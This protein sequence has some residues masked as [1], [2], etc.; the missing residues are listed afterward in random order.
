MAIDPTNLEII[1]YPHPTLRHKSKPIVKVDANLRDAIQAM[2][3]LM[4]EARGIGLAANQ[5][6]LPLRVFVLNLA[7]DPDEGEELVF[8]NPQINKPKGLD[9]KEEGCLSMPGVNGFVKRPDTIH[10]QAY[11]LSGNLFDATVDGLMARAIQHETDHLDGVLFTDKLSETGKLDIRDEL[12][13]LEVAFQST[14]NTGGVPDDATIAKR[15]K[16]IEQQYA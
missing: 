3:P 15:L 2:F 6:D 5:V 12:Y 11:D 14:Q 4:Y 8:I 7:A 1:H 9:E 10:V 16:T 13:E